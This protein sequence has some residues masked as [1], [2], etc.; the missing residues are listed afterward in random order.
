M[1]ILADENIPGTTVR[2][3]RD[4]RHDVLWIRQSFPGMADVDIMKLAVEEQRIIVTFDKDFGE[5]AVTSKDQN[6][7]GV[8]LLR[9]SKRS[10]SFIAETVERVLGVRDD[11]EGHL[12]VIDDTHIRMRPLENW[13]LP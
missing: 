3:L 12:A 11:W 5:L 4:G 6:P 8:I 13:R 10:P 9:I 2:Q 7:P 1:R